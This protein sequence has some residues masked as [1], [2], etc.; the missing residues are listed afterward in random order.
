MKNPLKSL[1]AYSLVGLLIL[2]NSSALA[3]KIPSR[4]DS[5]R[6]S[7][8]QE[9]AWWDLKH[10]DLS[11]EIDPAT[12]SIKGSNIIAYEVLSNATILQIDLQEPLKITSITQGGEPLTF[13]RE[14]AV[15]WVNPQKS[16]K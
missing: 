9:R 12:K 6:G 11:V 7:I 4:A 16:R 3:Q 5:L 14:G 2:L 13:R 10:Y 15:H 1:A 8:S